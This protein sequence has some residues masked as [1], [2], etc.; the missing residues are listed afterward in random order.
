MFFFFMEVKCE[1]PD[2]R[3]FTFCLNTSS[4]P[5]PAIEQNIGIGRKLRGVELNMNMN[6]YFIFIFVIHTDYLDILF[7]GPL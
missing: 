6:M 2:L 4:T 1:H 7:F 5:L 3:T